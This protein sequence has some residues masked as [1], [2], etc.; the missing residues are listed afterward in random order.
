MRG[1]Y[2]T[3]KG[4]EGTVSGDW[5]CPDA[6]PGWVK[7]QSNFASNYVGRTTLQRQAH[8]VNR[9]SDISQLRKISFRNAAMRWWYMIAA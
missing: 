8:R 5:S 7:Y 6:G 1:R 3:N 9:I 2:N 4:V